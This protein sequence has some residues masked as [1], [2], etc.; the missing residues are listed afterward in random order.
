MSALFGQS[1]SL[2]QERGQDIELLAWGDEFYVRYETPDGYAA[3]LDPTL[4]L[5]TYARLEDGRYVS[6]GVPVSQPPPVGLD[7]HLQETPAVR[8]A[9]SSRKRRRLDGR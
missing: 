6:S 7:K 9:Q 3:M 8:A 4:G 5:Y 2:A 1:V